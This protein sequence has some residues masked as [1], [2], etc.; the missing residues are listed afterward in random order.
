MYERVGH[1]SA[2]DGFSELTISGSPDELPEWLAASDLPLRFIDGDAGFV[3]ARI[4]TGAG[5]VV[6]P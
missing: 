2:P 1:T 4:S 5:A 3:E 6:L